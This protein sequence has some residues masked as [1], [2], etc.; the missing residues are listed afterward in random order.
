MVR[1]R[2]VERV[3]LTTAAKTSATAAVTAEG[4]ASAAVAGVVAATMENTASVITSGSAAQ[5][6]GKR[7]P[8]VLSAA[9]N[10][11]KTVPSIK[12][13][14]CI[15]GDGEEKAQG[16]EAPFV[17]M[18]RVM[19]G[20]IKKQSLIKGS[21]LEEI[22]AYEKERDAEVATWCPNCIYRYRN[23]NYDSEDGEY[24]E[25]SNS[26]SS[27]EV[28]EI[29]KGENGPTLQMDRDV[30]SQHSGKGNTLEEELAYARL[31]EAEAQCPNCEKP[32]YGYND[33]DES[34]EDEYGGLS[35][36]S[37]SESC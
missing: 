6:A 28:Q 27:E 3:V 32:K 15:R 19:A 22:Q 17:Q 2:K 8:Q 35:G 30:L 7:T 16:G 23:N 9:T 21:T 1:V 33:Q 36:S 20:V 26:E 37:V 5:A 24:E 4:T 12:K 13:P 14:R 29:T 11:N 31:N 34:D 25:N 10:N 18:A